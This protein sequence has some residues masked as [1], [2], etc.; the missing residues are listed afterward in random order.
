MDDNCTCV[1]DPCN[2]P[3]RLECH[4]T[5]HHSKFYFQSYYS[6]TPDLI[7]YNHETKYFE[8]SLSFSGASLKSFFIC[9]NKIFISIRIYEVVL[10]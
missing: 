2:E 1:L 8:L 6:A 5:F 7:K 9:L 3:A 4:E 10:Y